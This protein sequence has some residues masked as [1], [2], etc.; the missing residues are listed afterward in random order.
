M[1]VCI[2]RAMTEHEIQAAIELGADT[3]QALRSQ[4]GVATE[5]G[6]CAP[7]VQKILNN[8]RRS[9]GLRVRSKS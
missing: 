7:E 2:C 8:Y 3:M 9:H 5:C 1:Y 6:K 4:L